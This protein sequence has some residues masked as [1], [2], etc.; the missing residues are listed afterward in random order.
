MRFPVPYLTVFS[1]AL[2]CIASPCRAEMP[3]KTV[4]CAGSYPRHVQ[5]VCSNGKDAFFWSWTDSL[6]KTDL[7]GKI[8]RQVPAPDHQ[9][10]LCHVDGKIYVAVNLG[11]FNRPAGEADS[12]VFVYDADTLAELSRHPVP[13]LVHGAGGMAFHQGRFIIIGGLPPGTGENYA[14]EYD[15]G[16]KFIRRHTIN[17]GYTLMGIQTAEYADGSWWFGCYGKPAELLRTDE[18]F[19]V[20]GRWEFNAAV[21][22]VHLSADRFLVAENKGS[23]ETGNSARLRPARADSQKGLLFSDHEP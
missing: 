8:L 10:D 4:A 15:T 5:G 12:W 16:F 1:I 2:A 19:Q 21:G 20:T 6:V 13:E 3:F 14:Y 11:K 22:I 7:H 9:G 23:K 18:N 17:S